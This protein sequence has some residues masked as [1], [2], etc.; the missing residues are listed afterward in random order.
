MAL[1]LV[2]SNNRGGKQFVSCR[3]KCIQRLSEDE[4]VDEADLPEVLY[5]DLGR[6]Q[7]HS[8]RDEYLLR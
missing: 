8:L 6:N 3:N 1:Q 5:L 4:C 7:I 2:D